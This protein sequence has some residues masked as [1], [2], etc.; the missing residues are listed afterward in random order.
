MRAMLSAR[1][2]SDNWEK[3]KL[4]TGDK[5]TIE[6]ALIKL[7]AEYNDAPS[8]LQIMQLIR[9]VQNLSV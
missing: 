6:R 3:V 9:K 4:N 1:N 7:G 2:P 8:T 5:L